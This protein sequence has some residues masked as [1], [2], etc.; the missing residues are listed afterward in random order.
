MRRKISL[1]FCVLAVM[2]CFTACGSEKEAVKYDEATLEQATEF[3][4]EYC[5]TAD[6]ATVEQWKSLTEFQLELQLSQSGLPFTSESFLSA[7]DSW[8]QAINECGD[9][10]NHGD[11]AIEE[12]K[13][14]ILVSTEAQ[15]KDRDAT[16]EFI[17]NEDSY[18]DSMTI[19]AEYTTGE[20][21]EKAGLNTI[22][23][24]GTVFIVL[25]FISLL[26]SL[27]KFIPAIEK[28]F[29]KKNVEQGKENVIGEDTVI[30]EASQTD[31]LELVA[32]ISAAIAAA[33][34]TTTDRFVVR[35]IKRRSSNK[36]NS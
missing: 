36:W 26:I 8:D 13:D 16:I 3:L 28:A 29:K 5:S 4:I 18:L 23:G 6:E 1:V 21:L 19:S 25:I 20:I 15:F 30:A 35:S 12:T 24:M 11:Y 34:G 7:F 27:F 14:G 2:L 9:Y 10:I 33:E 17:F 22:L 32:V 31:D